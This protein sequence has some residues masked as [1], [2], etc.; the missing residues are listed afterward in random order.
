MASRCPQASGSRRAPDDVV[1]APAKRREAVLRVIHAARTRLI[2]SMFRCDD[3][4]V[5]DALAEARQRNVQVEALLTARAKGGRRRLRELGTVLEGIGVQV[6]RYADPIVKYHAKY[7]V[8]DDGPALV[9]S[10][11]FTRK[12]F[13]RTCD[14]V[15][16]THDA[17]V[18]AGL[19]AVF[20][21]DCRAPGSALPDQMSDRLIV[22]PDSSRAR[23]AALIQ[24]ARRSIRIIDAKLTDPAMVALLRKKSAEGVTVTLLE[25][26]SLG[27]LT[28]HGKLLLVDG[29]KAVVGSLSLSALSLAFRREV[30]IVVSDR[31]AVGRLDDFF[32]SLIGPSPSTRN[33]PPVTRNPERLTRDPRFAKDARS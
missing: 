23:F 6:H 4:Q 30:A 7:I 11:N 22:G 12:C 3:R 2:L 10:L 28:S 19:R 1:L 17:G 16:T 5:L 8:A 9:A 15:L 27:G 24:E 13:D 20:E 14:F 25:R 18:V 32:S 31:R 33:P 21:A 29:T 26:G